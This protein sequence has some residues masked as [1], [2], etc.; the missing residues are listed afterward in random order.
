MTQPIPKGKKYQKRPIKRPKP[1]PKH[2][3]IGVS[4]LEDRFARE[5][6]DKMGYIYERQFKAEDIGRYYDFAVKDENGMLVLIEV[7]GSYY[8]GYNLV[9]E[10]KNP[11]QKHNERVDKLKDLWAAEHSIPLL[12][13]WE[14]DINNNPKKVRKELE[15]F[16]GKAYEKQE[17]LNNKSKRH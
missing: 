11:M 14:H 6:L 1:Q 3:E 4:K 12:R 5:F 10:E 13:I 8:H 2:K 17:R 16:L 9:Y 15:E 7:D